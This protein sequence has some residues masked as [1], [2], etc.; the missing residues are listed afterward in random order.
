MLKRWE[1]LGYRR[2]LFRIAIISEVKSMIERL[3]KVTLNSGTMLSET[4]LISWVLS[5]Y[6]MCI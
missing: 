3:R 2:R 5:G 4:I 6:S 1:I